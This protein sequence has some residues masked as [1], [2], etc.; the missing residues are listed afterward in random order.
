MAAARQ[1]APRR[2]SRSKLHD[3]IWDALY[4]PIA[5]A[6]GFAADP[7]QSPSSFPDHPPVSSAWFFA[8]LVILLLVAR[9]MA[10]DPRISPSKGTQML[11]VLLLAPLLTGVVRKIKARFPAPARPAAH[12]ALPRPRAAHAQGGRAG[13]K[14][15][16]A[17][18]ASSPYLIFAATWVA[19][20][21][22]ADVPDRT[23][24]LPGRPI[25]SPSSR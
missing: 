6:V 22:V 9:H 24:V 8:A 1:H 14:R 16:L 3:L 19:A 25:S 10:P 4:A 12:P 23:A 7:P 17:G 20:S 5:A 11:L 18:F 2:G 15:L 21:L 13:R